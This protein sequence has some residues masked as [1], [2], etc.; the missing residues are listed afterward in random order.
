M[1]PYKKLHRIDLERK[2]TVNC[3][4]FSRAGAYL[5]V[6]TE[7]FTVEIYDCMS[8]GLLHRIDVTHSV[9]ALAWDQHSP[10]RLFLG[11]RSGLVLFCD[12]FQ[13]IIYSIASLCHTDFS[14][15][16]TEPGS[17]SSNRDCGMFG[18]VSDDQRSSPPPGHDYRL[19]SPSRK[20]ARSR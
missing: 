13:V 5:A 8:G 15:A 20:G 19:R 9:T 7:D 11:L 17:S 18:R 2:T 16:S 1:E 12:N 10:C 3:V 4:S 14:V 6:G